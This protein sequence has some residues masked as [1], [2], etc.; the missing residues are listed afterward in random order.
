MLIRQTI[1]YLPAQLIGPLS[2]FAMA[3]VLT[4]WLGA[5][6]YGL[7]MLIFASQELTFRVSLAWWTSYM[8][9]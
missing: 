4:H 5:A 7:T 8:M 9:R 6:E 1:A 2:Q 3:I